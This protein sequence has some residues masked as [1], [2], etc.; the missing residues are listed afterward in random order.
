MICCAKHETIVYDKLM[1][2]DSDHCH[3]SLPLSSQGEGCA[4]GEREGEQRE[5]TACTMAMHLGLIKKHRGK[6][7]PHINLS[8]GYGFN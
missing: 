2:C 1:V 6:S 7:R 5:G 3:L 4:M 8:I